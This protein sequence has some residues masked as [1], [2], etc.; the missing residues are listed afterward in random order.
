MR[1]DV[2]VSVLTAGGMLEPREDWTEQARANVLA[3]LASQQAKRGGSAKI[4]VTI[5][6]AGGDPKLVAEL[7]RLHQAVGR[8]IQI[9]K[10]TPGMELPTKKNVFDWTLGEAA[11]NF[12]RSTGYDY[13]LFLYASDSFSSGGRIALQ[14]VSVLGC[15][16]GVCI[17]PAGGKQI[18]FVSLVDL[19]DGRVVWYNYLYSEDGDIRELEGAAELVDRLLDDMRPAKPAKSKG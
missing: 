12:G 7:D 16:V 15:V 14:A 8:S 19:K 11:V 18:A 1:P 2:T 5:Q 17:I 4:A 3:A 13:A 10:Y 9:H 6:D